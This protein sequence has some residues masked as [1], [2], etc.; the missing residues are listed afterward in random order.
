MSTV[1]IPDILLPV[2]GTD[3]SRWAVNACD[4]FTSDGE[5][6]RQL[7]EYVGG[8]PSALNLIYP[9]IYLKENRKGRIDGI[10]AKTVQ[11]D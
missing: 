11:T 7:E 5:Y 9:E 6:W 4:Q 2:Q 8:S 10:N 3:M 1:V